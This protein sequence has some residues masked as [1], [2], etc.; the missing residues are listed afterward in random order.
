MVKEAVKTAN[1]IKKAYDIA[2]SYEYME[3]GGTSNLD[4][5][6]VEFNNPSKIFIEI[7]HEVSG[8]NLIKYKKNTFLIV[9]GYQGAV[10]TKMAQV[11]S[12]F[13][14]GHGISSYV[15]YDLD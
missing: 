3:D 9:T 12:D 6:L 15:T 8:V 5:C 14:K 10:R 1:L 2:S 4:S 7:V 11:M 13:L